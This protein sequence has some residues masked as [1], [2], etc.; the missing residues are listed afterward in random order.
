MKE[1]FDGL[2]KLMIQ[3]MGVALAALVGAIASLIGVIA[4]ILL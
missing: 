1:G 4:T 2:Q 3:F